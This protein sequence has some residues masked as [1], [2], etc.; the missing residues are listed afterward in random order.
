[1]QPDRPFRAATRAPAATDRRSFVP[2][3]EQR[4]Q[5]LDQ[6]FTDAADRGLMLRNA[7]DA[8]LN[9]RY[10]QFDGKEYLNFSS[11]SYLGLEMDPRL[12]EGAAAAA[13]RYGT[14]FSSSRSYVSAPAYHELEE[15][16]EEIFDG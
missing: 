11:C 8:V 3:A 4:L 6:M 10:L 9:G 13:M 1:M 15:A 16:L 14:Q 5:I 12:K 7:D 2:K